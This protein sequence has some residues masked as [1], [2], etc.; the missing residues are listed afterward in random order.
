[1]RFDDVWRAH[2]NDIR[3]FVSSKVSNPADVDDLLQDVSTKAYINLPRLSEGEKL[4]S[5]LFQIANRSIIDFYRKNARSS[6]GVL[7]VDPC[8]SANDDALADLEHCVPSLIQDMPYETR[9][10]LTAV[11]LEG[12]S[13]K[14]YARSL[15]ISYST[16]KSRVQRGR[17]ALL[18]AFE[19]CCG[20][21]F[22]RP[23]ALSNCVINSNFCKK[24]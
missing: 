3:K 8:H 14:D 10:V 6:N 24:C 23:G 1:M 4:K 2:R 18:A 9:T 19:D 20:I 5:W 15:G 22:A 11:D 17:A 13:Q 16:L 12:H 7:M 21:N